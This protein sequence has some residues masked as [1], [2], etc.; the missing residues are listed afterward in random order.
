VIHDF[1]Q[2]IADSEA[3]KHDGEQFNDTFLGGA[4]TLLHKIYGAIGKFL[5]I[6]EPKLLQHIAGLAEKTMDLQTQKT[7]KG[8][9]FDY[10][11]TKKAA[12]FEADLVRSMQSQFGANVLEVSR[13]LRSLTGRRRQV[14]ARSKRCG[15]KSTTKGQ[16]W[17]RYAN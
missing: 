1:V 17:V 2:E 16:R 8:K 14:R 4:K 13:A 11:G 7:A 3:F 15:N 10:L 9:A 6:Q 5:G 12:D